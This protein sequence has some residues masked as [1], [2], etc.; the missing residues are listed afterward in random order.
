MKSCPLWLVGIATCCISTA[1]AAQP[2]GQYSTERKVNFE[3]GNAQMTQ[4]LK[5][6]DS[7]REIVTSGYVIAAEDLNDDKYP[8]IIVLA[9]SPA[10]CGDG[11]CRMVVLRN[12]GPARFETLGEFFASRDIGV[13]RQ[14][15]NGYRLLAKLDGKGGVALAGSKPIVYAM[16]TGAVGATTATTAATPS[17]TSALATDGGAR[18]ELLNVKLGMTLD[19][20]KAALRSLKPPLAPNIPDTRV[21]VPLLPDG[22]FVPSYYAPQMSAVPGTTFKTATVQFSPPPGASRA[23]AI[24]QTVQYGSKD[25]PTLDNLLTALHEKYGNPH[26][27]RPTAQGWAKLYWAWSPEGVPLAA[28]QRQ[29]CDSI[30][31]SLAAGN[32]TPMYRSRD[33]LNAANGFVTE[34]RKANC[35]LYAYA[36]YGSANSFVQ[37]L[38]VVVV[39]LAAAD[40]ALALTVEEVD[41]LLNA[42][43]DKALE[44]AKN[45]KPDL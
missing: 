26:Q 37:G 5:S 16:M 42:Q 7:I 10:F 44:D 41:G 32:Y 17:A 13:T 45:R 31:Q 12:T 25:A 27:T 29:R 43:N 4:G 24:S 1:G 20:A 28:E 2:L 18:R 23:I 22:T 9:S 30:G 15:A 35:G 19:E 21:A 34:S 11:G 38:N 39:D 40:A 8:E 14:K 36:D 6:V 3:P 33:F